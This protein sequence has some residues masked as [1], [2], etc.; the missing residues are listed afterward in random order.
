MQPEI[1]L[2]L[3]KLHNELQVINKKKE[4]RVVLLKT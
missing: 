4:M 2:M 3:L 1:D